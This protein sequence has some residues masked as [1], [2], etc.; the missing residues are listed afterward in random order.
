MS[1]CETISD[2]AQHLARG[3]IASAER[4]ANA[5]L[6]RGDDPDALHLLALT[7]IRQN[8]LDEAVTLL[9]RAL[10]A[11]PRQAHVLLNLGKVFLLLKRDGEALAPL[12]QAVAAQPALSEAWYE[13]GEL[14]HRLGDLEGAEVSMRQVLAQ[15][16][17]HGLAKLS[18]GTVLKDAGRAEEAETLLAGALDGAQDPRLKAGIAYNL[19]LAQYDQGKKEA[20]LANFT[21]VRRLDP[22]RS[23][24]EITRSDLLEELSRFDE[25]ETLLQAL[26]AREPQNHDAHAAYNDL[27]YRLRRDEEFLK[28][29]DRAPASLPLM[30]GK[31]RFL[32]Q[33]NRLEEA[34][35]LYAGV[36]AREP[37]DIDAVIGAAAA[38]SR[39]GRHDEAMAK[40]QPA[41]A[42]DPQNPALYHHLAATALEAREPQKAAA[43]AEQSLKL[44][45]LSY[46]GL[47]LLGSAWRM[48]GDDR[49]E[50]LNGYDELIGIFDLEP[51]EGYSSMAA[52]NEDLNTWLARQ[53][54]NMREPLVQSLRGGSQTRGNIFNQRHGLMDRLKARIAEAM[55]AYIAAIK[56]DAGHPFRGRR[57]AGF[58]FT[59]SWSSRLRDCGYHINHIHPEGWISS[60]YYVGMP[61]AARDETTRQG[62]IKF[63][64]PG[65]ETGLG[66]RRAIQPVPGRLVLFPSYMWHGTIPFQSV[67]PRTTIA[68]DAVPAGALSAPAGTPS[69][70]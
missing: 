39:M 59:G 13:L 64:E 43:L 7:R 65:L 48:L 53:H 55:T 16:P 33:T 26:L 22:A 27:L 61:D 9:N 63:G 30:M 25:A 54:T 23:S 19:A 34:H 36:L 35:A 60:C 49:D 51:P 42:R 69:G 56:P 58:R 18:L 21:L 66:P 11:R 41:S 32:L 31:A 47:A 12:S 52:F 57:G 3:D 20:A 5:F 70:G 24:V 37:H 38:L 2:G 15:E 67:T 28:S 46:Y 1:V 62:W 4:V 45:P 50:R 6:V 8:R 14:Q 40:L 44:A 10:A 68:F 29:Y 17:A